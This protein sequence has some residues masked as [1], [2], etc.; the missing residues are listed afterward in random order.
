MH[1]H[2]VIKEK[3]IILCVDFLFVCLLTISYHLKTIQYLL[4]KNLN[5]KTLGNGVTLRKCQKII[6][7]FAKIRYVDCSLPM[8]R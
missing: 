3:G 5:L 8:N 6:C 7:L 2:L 4:T 1:V